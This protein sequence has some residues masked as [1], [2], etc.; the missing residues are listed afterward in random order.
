MMEE[1]SGELSEGEDAS[2][3]SATSSVS[4][5]GGESQSASYSECRSE[6]DSVEGGSSKGQ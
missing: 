3:N 4:N 1:G 6:S 5:L 2:N